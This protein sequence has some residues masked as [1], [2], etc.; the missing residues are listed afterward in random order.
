[1]PLSEYFRR[2]FMSLSSFQRYRRLLKELR[3]KEEEIIHDERVK[4]DDNRIPD[5]HVPDEGLPGANDDRKEKAEDEGTSEDETGEEK[6][7]N[8]ADDESN[9]TKEGI[10]EAAQIDPEAK[11]GEK[12]KK[13]KANPKK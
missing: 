8:G 6:A 5:V 3:E 10:Q 2:G 1:M 13:L 11:T 4:E 7:D 9:G 12:A